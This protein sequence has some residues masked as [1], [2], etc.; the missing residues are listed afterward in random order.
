MDPS[1]PGPLWSERVSKGAR[2]S[3]EEPPSEPEPDEPEPEQ[4]VEAEPEP[5]PEP[6]PEPEPDLQEIALEQAQAAF[7]PF[8]EDL[9]DLVDQELL[10]KVAVTVVVDV[11]PVLFPI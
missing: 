8:A 9:A 2:A 7:M 11:M 4:V 1:P 10:E 5:E 3:R 6:V